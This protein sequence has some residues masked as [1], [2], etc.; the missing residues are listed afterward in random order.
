MCLKVCCI[1]V[2]CHTFGDSISKGWPEDFWVLD[3]VFLLMNVW[4]NL[5][6]RG[7][8]LSWCSPNIR[9]CCSKCFPHIWLQLYHGSFVRSAIKFWHVISLH[10]WHQNHQWWSW[11]I[12]DVTCDTVIPVQGIKESSHGVLDIYWGGERKAHLFGKKNRRPL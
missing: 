7:I 11:M 8:L 12:L 2:S 1:K 4:Y 10:V 6:L 3:V 5:V 9:L